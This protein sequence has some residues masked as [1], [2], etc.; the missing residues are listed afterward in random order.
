MQLLIDGDQFVY[1]AAAAVETEVRWDNHHHV[2]YSNETRAWDVL[3]GMLK[4]IRERFGSSDTVMC[5]SGPLVDGQG[6][7]T[8][9]TLLDP[10]Y[11]SGRSRKPLCYTLLREK[12]EA[13]EK[14]QS[15]VGLEADDVMGILATKP[16]AEAIIISQDKDMKTV[17]AVVWD[18][19]DLVTVSPDEADYFHLLQ[20][21]TGDPSDGYKG[22]P[23]MGPV[24]AKKLLEPQNPE[25]PWF[26]VSI[27]WPR[28]VKAYEK[29]KLTEAD[30]LTQARLARIL[31]WS[32]WDRKNKEPILWTP[33]NP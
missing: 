20:T 3:Q 15:F 23:G 21:L 25:H 6:S 11:K 12:I 33:T 8:F 4:R 30:A 24:K 17:P 22:C 28:V 32:D 31:R 7:P 10:T 16:G 5:F 26:D 19:R 9:R 2:L 29:A 1:K 14:H 18:G 13:E 27:L